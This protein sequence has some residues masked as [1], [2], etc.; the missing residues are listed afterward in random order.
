MRIFSADDGSDLTGAE[1]TETTRRDW[2]IRRRVK[3]KEEWHL[4]ASFDPDTWWMEVQNAL[5][6]FRREEGNKQP[7]VEYAAFEIITRRI[8]TKR[9]W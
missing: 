2:E 5:E 1:R 6:Y 7:G 4:F 3:G 9:S 8:E